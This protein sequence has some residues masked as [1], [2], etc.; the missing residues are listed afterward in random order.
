MGRLSSLVHRRTRAF[1]PLPM[2]PQYK[3]PQKQLVLAGP[4]N[5][6]SALDF[7]GVFQPIPHPMDCPS[8]L[9]SLPTTYSTPGPA[10]KNPG[11]H[12]PLR[13][14]GYT[15]QFLMFPAQALKDHY[16]HVPLVP[17]RFDPCDYVLITHSAPTGLRQP[18]YL[19]RL[20]NIL[21]LSH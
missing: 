7:P 6:K 20:F 19:G 3:A 10:P 14:Q 8:F 17:S 9:C 2:H 13:E 15:Q 1:I 18:P 11:V 21:T 12:I 16:I 5:P 4:A